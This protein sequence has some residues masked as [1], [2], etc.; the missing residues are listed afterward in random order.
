M[1][2]LVLAA[3]LLAALFATGARAADLDDPYEKYSSPYADPRYAD[4]Y[5]YPRSAPPPVPPGH[6]YRHYDDDDD[7][8]WP[9]RYAHADPRDR[10]CVPRREIKH[11]LKDTGW[12]DFHDVDLRGELAIVRARRPSGRL[13]ELTIHRC[14]GEIVDAQPL[15]SKHFGP[16]AYGTRRWGP[17]Y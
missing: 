10:Y 11:R 5:K 17:P 3:G 2:R 12:H 4:I 1:K 14:S 8:R 13:F 6:V 7:D 16:Y 15:R 9:R